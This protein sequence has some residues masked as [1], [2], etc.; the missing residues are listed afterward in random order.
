MGFQRFWPLLLVIPL[1]I[2]GAFF[3]R[4]PS[5]P[6]TQEWVPGARFGAGV[7]PAAEPEVVIEP[8]PVVVVPLA[9]PPAP[10]PPALPGGTIGHDLAQFLASPGGEPSRRFVFDGL[11]F[12][13]ARANLMPGAARTLDDVAAVLEAYPGAEVVIEGHTD[14]TGVPADNQRLSLARADAVKHALVARG[15][16]ADRIKTQGAGQERP[17][18]SNATVEGRAKNRRTE[19]FVTR[20]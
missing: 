5:A 8:P 3:F 19:L 9:P 7:P 12:E 1:A 15:V 14:A 2:L 10:A 16:A 18:A 11:T 4:K 13:L 20:R 17:V 6:S